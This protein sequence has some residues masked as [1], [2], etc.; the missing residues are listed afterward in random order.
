MGKFPKANY[1][2]QLSMHYVYLGRNSWD[3]LYTSE[4]YHVKSMIILVI[5]HIRVDTEN[6]KQ[7][8]CKNYQ[9]KTPNHNKTQLTHWHLGDF[10][11]I[12]GR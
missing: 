7:K 2:T 9:T 3:I 12:L 1:K 5:I 8:L 11:L 6:Y 4:Q 10:N